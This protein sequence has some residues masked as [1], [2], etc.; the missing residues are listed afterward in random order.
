M[1]ATQRFME[2]ASEE[3]SV[4]E[5]RMSKADGSLGWF[6][7]HE[8]ATL[9]G[10]G[11][12]SGFVVVIREVSERKAR[13]LD[14]TQ[15]AVTD[16]LTGLLNRRGFTERFERMNRSLDGRDVGCVAL[17]D[18]DHFK[19]VNDRHGHAV[20]DRLLVAF[21]ETLGD[22]L[23]E[24]DLAGRIGGEE[25]AAYFAGR[26]MDEAAGLCD[27]VRASF[28]RVAIRAEGGR[29]GST[30]VTIGLVMRK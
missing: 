28:E 5:F 11:H 13:E 1:F 17:F 25:F 15:A 29:A 16:S 20:G 24:T 23:G 3:T 12:V 2:L 4:V 22:H 10:D 8:R 19:Q 27:A 6:E 21:A 30:T 26:T 18:L 9:D 7:S 14:L